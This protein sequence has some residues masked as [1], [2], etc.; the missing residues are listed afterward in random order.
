[1]T[2]ARHPAKVTLR[3]FSNINTRST[4]STHLYDVV[5]RLEQRDDAGKTGTD[6][7]LV[8]LACAGMV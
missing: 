1:M 5:S 3:R 2:L 8:C 6:T 7:V 4:F